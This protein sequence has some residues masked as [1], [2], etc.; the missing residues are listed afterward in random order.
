MYK[1]DDGVHEC[2]QGDEEDQQ[3]L[4]GG[5]G[6]CQDQERG[7]QRGTNHSFKKNHQKR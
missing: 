3:D 5:G 6:V 7:E 2:C 1:N 4:Q